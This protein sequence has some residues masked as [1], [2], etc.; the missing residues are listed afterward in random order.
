MA[1]EV[2][3]ARVNAL[4]ALGRRKDALA[5]LESLPEAAARGRGLRALRG[6]LLVHE[7][8]CVEALALLDPLLAEASLDDAA[9]RALFARASCR[10][11][12]GQ[13]EAS[14]ADLRSYLEHFP[15]GRFA[16]EARRALRR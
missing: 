7:G 1:D 14:A 8:R 15:R 6:E 16:E 12:M 11:R 2:L 3:A 4:V 5:T 13:F 9:E 10:G